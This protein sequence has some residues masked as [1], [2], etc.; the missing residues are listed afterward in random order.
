MGA[1]EIKI[2]IVAQLGGCLLLF[3]AVKGSFRTTKKGAGA[4]S[5]NKASGFLPPYRVQDFH[6]QPIVD[7]E[8]L[9]E[10]QS[11]LEA[12]PRIPT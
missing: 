1:N 7:I 2:K 6:C 12:F 8:K 9:V 3:P 5:A 4:C 11:T 10:E